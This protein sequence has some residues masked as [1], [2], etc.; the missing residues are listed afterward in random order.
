MPVG[1]EDINTAHTF[2]F[3]L[4][5]YFLNAFSVT[6]YKSVVEKQCQS[7]FGL[8]ML[9]TIF[10]MSLQNNFYTKNKVAHNKTKEANRTNLF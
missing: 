8:F 10:Y 3:S 4:L 7:V 1:N 2:P 6:T 5:H 9:T